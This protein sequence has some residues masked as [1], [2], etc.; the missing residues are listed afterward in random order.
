MTQKTYTEKQGQY[1]AFIYSYTQIH[2]VPPAEADLRRHFQ[3]TAPTV[4]GMIKRL[5]ALGLV[6]RVPGKG[7]TLE[8][9]VD[10][11]ALPLLQ[12]P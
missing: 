4:H 3:T 2:G 9:Q 8:I 7:R 1:L 11:K 6:T 12:R 10:P 5:T